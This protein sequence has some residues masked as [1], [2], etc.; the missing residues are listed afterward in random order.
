MGKNTC[1]QEWEQFRW[2][3]KSGRNVWVRCVV[4]S[5]TN[6]LGSRTYTSIF[7]QREIFQ[8]AFVTKPHACVKQARK[9]R[10]VT[11]IQRRRSTPRAMEN[12]PRKK[13]NQSR[14]HKPP[15]NQK[16]HQTRATLL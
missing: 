5:C 10:T 12:T 8:K 16:K 15:R 2:V 7:M 4:R 1:N 11:S 3:E 6:R 14:K 9:S 13:R